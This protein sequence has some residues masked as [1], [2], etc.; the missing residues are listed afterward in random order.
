[1]LCR[2][3]SCRSSSTR[4]RLCPRCWWEG[5]GPA[6]PREGTAASGGC[7][8]RS[9]WLGSGSRRRPL[10][11]FPGRPEPAGGGGGTAAAAVP[12]RRRALAGRR[13]CRRARLRGTAARSRGDRAAVRRPGRR[14]SRVRRTRAGRGR[15]GRG[16][17]PAGVWPPR[18]GWRHPTHEPKLPSNDDARLSGRPDPPT[19]MKHGGT[20]NPCTPC[21]PHQFTTP[22]HV[23]DRCRQ[24]ADRS[25]APP[26]FGTPRRSSVADC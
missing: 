24:P 2:R 22:F 23:W 16:T 20:P 9:A 17:H 13:L 4:E 5:C 21:H 11:R 14:S 1:M 3:Y 10:S 7:P 19:R 6:S 8:W 15:A 25:E 12:H 26:T 18:P